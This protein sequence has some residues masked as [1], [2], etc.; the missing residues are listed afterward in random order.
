MDFRTNL[1]VEL[2]KNAIYI[3]KF[4]LPYFLKVLL[5]NV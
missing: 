1:P 4:P 2:L 3:T 5:G